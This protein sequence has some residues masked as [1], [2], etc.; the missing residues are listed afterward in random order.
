MGFQSANI[1]EKRL[2]EGDIIV[3]PEQ[4]NTLVEFTFGP[5]NE[6]EV[7]LKLQLLNFIQSIFISSFKG[8]GID[9]EACDCVDEIKNVFDCDAECDPEKCDCLDTAERWLTTWSWTCNAVHSFEK[10]NEKQTPASIFFIE[11]DAPYPEEKFVSIFLI[12]IIL[13]MI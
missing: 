4:W 7:S 9:R 13:N 5:K 8:P 12:K 3:H 11:V 6:D 2:E 10:L 1:T